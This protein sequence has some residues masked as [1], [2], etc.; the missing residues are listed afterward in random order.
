MGQVNGAMV[1]AGVAFMLFVAHIISVTWFLR[2]I[3]SRNDLV[4]QSV[5]NLG[6]ELRGDIG[7]LDHSIRGLSSKVDGVIRKV[8]ELAVG[9][10]V[11]RQRIDTIEKEGKR[12][13]GE[14][15]KT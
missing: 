15:G 6:Q 8:N 9:V 2:G 3:R 11:T 4:V 10:A 12:G 1:A 13:Q 14:V 5:H 7:R